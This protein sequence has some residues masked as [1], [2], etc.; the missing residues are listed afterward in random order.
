MK[1]I[2]KDEFKKIVIDIIVNVDRICR[3][4]S[5]TYYLAFGSLI[6]AIRHKGI[7]PWDDDIDIMMPRSDYERFIDVM[8]KQKGESIY[9][10][11]CY[12]TDP[13]FYL[14]WARVCNNTTI[15][16][17]RPHRIEKDLG[18]W[19][20]V[21]PI[22]NAPNQEDRDS[23]YKEYQKRRLK[24]AY[25][26][27]TPYEQLN[28]R[29]QIFTKVFFLR[30]FYGVRNFLKYRDSCLEWETKFNGEECNE[31]MIPYTMYGMRCVFPKE[32]FDDVVEVEFE[33]HNF[34]A[35]KGYDQF[36]KIVYGDYM[37]L[38]PENKRQTHHHFTAFYK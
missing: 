20:D 17:N 5:I 28:F 16:L 37:Q 14:P 15:L 31:V 19:I 33:H 10:V 32:I 9:Q 3:D 26:I 21:F 6:G 34:F 4:N 23:W 11:N 7:I 8:M 22:D 38:P 12:E 27:P 30:C 2:S 24:M 29:K 1:E 36:L 25:T 13:T 35:P 18:V